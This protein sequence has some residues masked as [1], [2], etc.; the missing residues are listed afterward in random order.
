LAPLIEPAE[1]LLSRVELD[2]EPVLSRVV[3][4]AA[5]VLS[6]VVLELVA[7][8]LWSLI[9]P[10]VPSLAEDPGV[11]ERAAG[12]PGGTAGR[13]DVE[14]VP[15]ERVPSAR[16]FSSHA[17]T[18]AAEAIRPAIKPKVFLILLSFALT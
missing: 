5:P 8:A 4:D 2:A 17:V 10:L 11:A 13:P 16:F 9:E 6:R 15:S 18:S 1:P 3:P 7:P 14:V 12:D